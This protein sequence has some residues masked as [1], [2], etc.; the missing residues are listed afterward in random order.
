MIYL[1][2]S[3]RQLVPAGTSTRIDLDPRNG[4]IKKSR[5]DLPRA[6]VP[7]GKDLKKIIFTTFLNILLNIKKQKKKQ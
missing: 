2:Y 4:F 1:R 5:K 3:T 6:R 7:L